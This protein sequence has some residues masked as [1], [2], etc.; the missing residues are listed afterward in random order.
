MSK[1]LCVTSRSLCREDFLIRL[2]KI[3]RA[4]CAGILLREKDL[5]P[6][7][8]G[9]LAERVLSLCRAHQ[10]PCILHSHAETAAELGAPA[11]HLPLP[12]LEALPAPLR[13]KFSSLGASCHS[14]EDA[15][16][17]QALGC[18][19]LTAGHIFATDCKKGLAP[20]GLEFLREVCQAVEIPVWAIGGIRPENLPQ[21]LAAGAA[22]GCV[23]SGLMACPDPAA[24]L[25]AFAAAE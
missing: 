21:V 2:E 24:A 25:A 23:M 8:Y 12:L 5:S 13:G 11:L 9:E 6:R 10:V 18:T 14:V 15:L 19:Y 22:G 16:R 7:Q 20:R 17:A 1:V 3:A 4:G